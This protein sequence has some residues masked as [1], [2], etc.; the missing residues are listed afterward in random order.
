MLFF[1]KKLNILAKS[2]IIIV[3]K[4]EV[5]VVGICKKNY[6]QEKFSYVKNSKDEIFQHKLAIYM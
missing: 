1:S 2:A 5:F 3:R 4:G 6:H